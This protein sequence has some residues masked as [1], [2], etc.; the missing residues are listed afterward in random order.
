MEIRNI[1]GGYVFMA[2]VF[3][4]HN[5]YMLVGVQNMYLQNEKYPNRS[6]SRSITSVQSVRFLGMTKVWV[7]C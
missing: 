5:I 2:A 4:F 1:G 3:P 6:P 7:L